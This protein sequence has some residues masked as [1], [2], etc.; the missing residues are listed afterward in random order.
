MSDHLATDAVRPVQGFPP[1]DIDIEKSGNADVRA[2]ETSSNGDD[3]SV[4]SE[5]FQNGVQRVRAITEIWSKQT[6]ITMFILYVT[7]HQR[8]LVIH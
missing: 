4:E 3:K 8:Y 6:L 5:T 7:L 2:H 1:K